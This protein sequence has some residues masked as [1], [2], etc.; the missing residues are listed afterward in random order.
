MSAPQV[1]RRGLLI[2]GVELPAAAGA[3]T[4][5]TDPYTAQVYAYIAAGR[6]EDVARA[7]D[8]AQQ[9]FPGWAG[10]SA[11]QRRAVLDRAAQLLLDRLDDFTEILRRETGGTAKWARF[12]IIG[13]ARMMQEATKAAAGA[14]LEAIGPATGGD[15][16][17]ITYEAAGVVAAIVPWNAPLVLAVRAVTVALAVGNTVVMRPSEDAPIASGLF[18][19]DVLAEAGL[20]A[21]VLNVVTNDR[22]DA[23][24]VIAA[25]IADS[26]V[27]RVGFTGSTGVGQIVGELAGRHLTPVVLE[28]GGKNPIIVLDD[29]DL[30]QA[31]AQILFTRFMNSGQICL[32]VDRIILHENIAEEFT[33]RFVQRAG[34]LAEGDPAKPDTIVGPLINQRAVDRVTAL[35]AEAVDHGATMLL[36]GRA[37][38][39]NV[40]PATVLT[41][42]TPAMR[43]YHEEI[44]GPVACLYT[45]ADDDAAVALA[46]DTDYGLTSAVFGGD[47]SRTLALAGLLRHGTT[48]I[49]HHTVDEDPYSPVSSFRDSGFGSHWDPWFF[50]QSRLLGQTDAPAALPF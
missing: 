42:I 41:G 50:T 20:P 34:L 28:L 21:G 8:A 2:G 32:S 33:T 5:D 27:R 6:A 14:N 10:A 19:A 44:F 11:A 43:I 16:S 47:R 26:R 24:E 9:A 13:A 1:I 29:A 31:V 3:E 18:L 17:A 45:V 22:A 7:V 30:D 36:G 4:T 15:W 46:N 40:F 49:N 39:G 38:V 37:P 48:H 25:L 35:V 12:N 23:A